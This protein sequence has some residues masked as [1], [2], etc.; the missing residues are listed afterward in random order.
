MNSVPPKSIILIEDIDAIF[1]GREVATTNK[2]RISFSGLLNALDGVK[3]QDGRILFMTTN[4]K[5]KL[6]PALLRPGR[7]DKKIN[8]QNASHA[9]MEKLFLKFFLD[10]H[11]NA[12]RFATQLPDY[13]LSMAS[14]QE[15]LVKH[16]ESVTEC[17]KRAPDMLQ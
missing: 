2:C 14:V 10:D 7:A 6:D 12:T 4:H 15:H 1:V 9:Q 17:V 3:T 8:L 13:K 11:D 16:S 5:D